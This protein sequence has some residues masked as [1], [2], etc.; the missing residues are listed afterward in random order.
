[1]SVRNRS[2]RRCRRT[3]RWASTR[4]SAVRVIWPIDRDQTL[5]FEALDHL[6]DGR[7]ADHQPFGDPGLDDVDVVLL[8]LED[9]LAVL[10]ECRMVLSRGGHGGNPT[11]AYLPRA[12]RSQLSA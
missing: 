5:G 8:Q 10:L 6:A 1:M 12:R 3:T 11:G 9:A 4:P 2:A 7:P